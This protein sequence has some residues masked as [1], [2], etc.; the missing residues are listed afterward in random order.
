M[1]ICNECGAVFD[2]PKGVF[3]KVGELPTDGH[4]ESV[5]PE[6]GGDDIEDAERCHGC[7]EYKAKS[8]LN[9]G[10]CNECGAEV[11]KKAREFWT[12]LT[13][14]EQEYLRDR[15]CEILDKE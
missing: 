10:F 8:T 9:D 15:I 7:D 4:Y 1:I 13:E 12:G 14:A 11:E 3:N 5:C 6:C 2:E